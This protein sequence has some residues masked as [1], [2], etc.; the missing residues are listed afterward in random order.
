[1]SGLAWDRDAPTDTRLCSITSP[2]GIVHVSAWR[3]GNG[4][5]LKLA[6]SRTGR[7]ALVDATVL[8]ALCSLTP[9]QIKQTIEASTAGAGRSER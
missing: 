3:T 7:S 1:M 9:A 8:D 4:M 2:L 5:R 6:S